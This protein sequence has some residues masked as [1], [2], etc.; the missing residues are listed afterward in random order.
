MSERSNCGYTI[1][2]SLTIGDCEFV[3][4]HNPEAPNPYVTW[5]CSNGDYYFWGHYSNDRMAADRDLLTRAVQ[6][7]IGR[8]SAWVS[9]RSIKKRSVS[10]DGT[11]LLPVGRNPA[12]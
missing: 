5:K 3:L 8:N 4:G 2:Q 10:D 12:L 9:S 11:F 6:E 1:V 7:W